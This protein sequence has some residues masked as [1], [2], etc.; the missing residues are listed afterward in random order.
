[1]ERDRERE[2]ILRIL[3]GERE[4]FALLVDEYKTAVF[5]LT[6]RMTGSYEDASDLA[7]EIFVRAYKNLRK[8]QTDRS[9]F[10][11]LYTISLNHIR[12]H[13]RK[14]RLAR[15][16]FSPWLRKNDR[17]SV[18][19]ELAEGWKAD[20]ASQYPFRA[21]SDIR[22][23]SSPE[24]SVFPGTPEDDILKS[25]EI[26]K[27]ARCLKSLPLDQREAVVLR[28]YQG[29]SFAEIAAISGQSESAVK[30]RVYRGLEKLK[31]RMEED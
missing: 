14:E 10:T 20:H 30:M 25:E 22:S 4:A 21:A 7:Q 5:N 18:R 19:P 28:F 12:N 9:F 8:F 2:I 29:F 27:L 1:M 15:T 26:N 24:A 13:L 17:D 23:S 11:W 3:Q 31:K 16:I 6:Y